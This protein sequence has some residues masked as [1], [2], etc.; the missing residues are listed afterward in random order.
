MY[1][2]FYSVIRKYISKY[3]FNKQKIKNFTTVLIEVHLR[4]NTLVYK[5]YLIFIDY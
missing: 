1:D 2:I 3:Y 4:K 5:F